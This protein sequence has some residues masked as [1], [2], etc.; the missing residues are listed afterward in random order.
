MS[1]RLYRLFLP[2]FLAAY[3]L[4]G[5]LTHS[6]FGGHEVFPLFSWALYADAPRVET[7]YTIR[8]LEIDGRPY[9]PPLELM[10]DPAFHRRPDYWS[11]A[12]V[13]GRF[14][15]VLD[16]KDVP[17]AGRLRALVEGNILPGR[18]LR[19]E[20]VKR[21]FAPLDRRRGGGFEETG[22]GVFVKDATAKEE[23]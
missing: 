14:G 12:G 10:A 9:E 11:D 17:G 15:E 18:R 1:P 6:R 13:V 7:Q 21:V 8:L 16:R 23:R 2:L 19:Y 20:V 5:L 22:L 4:G 3:G